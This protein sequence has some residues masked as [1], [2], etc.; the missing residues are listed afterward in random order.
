MKESK[1][2]FQKFLWFTI[3]LCV[4]LL[5]VTTFSFA[6]GG[7]EDDF[8]GPTLDSAWEVWPGWNNS[9]GS[10]SI[11]N[12]A[13]QYMLS[14][15]QHDA[16]YY[17]TPN[18]SGG[19]TYYPGLLLAR[20]FSGDKWTFETK[21]NYNMPWSN[22]RALS[23]QIWIGNDG[24]RPSMGSSGETF[25][26]VIYRNA[27]QAGYG[28]GVDYLYVWCWPSGQQIKLP[29]NTSHFR[30]IRDGY[31]FTLM[32]SSDGI[33]Y[34]TAFSVTAPSSVDGKAQKVVIGGNSWARPA[35]SYEAYDYIKVKVDPQPILTK[36]G[37]YYQHDTTLSGQPGYPTTDTPVTVRAIVWA[38][39]SPN[40][41]E[42]PYT[43]EDWPA[44]EWYNPGIDGAT[45]NFNPTAQNLP[46]ITE[47]PSNWPQVDFEWKVLFHKGSN[48]T[49]TIKDCS[50]PGH[51]GYDKNGNKVVYCDK[52]RNYE[53]GYYHN[54]LWNSW[55]GD[56]ISFP[57]GNWRFMVKA[58]LDKGTPVESPDEEKATRISV[59]D[60]DLSIVYGHNYLKWL[61]AYL[62]VPYEWGGY[63]FGG[64]VGQDVG[65]HVTYEDYGI[66][67]S[68]FV[69]CGA[70]WS[71]YNWS[72]WRTSTRTLANG[73]P[74]DPTYYSSII[75]EK[76]LAPGDI[77]N[78]EGH[79]V[80]TIYKIEN[81]EEGTPKEITVIEA[82]G[83]PDNKVCFN[84]IDWK[85]WKKKGYKP[86]RLT[87]H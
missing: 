28:A 47:W 73:L 40:G 43:Q 75:N 56:N 49:S 42:K 46:A 78:W 67:C 34:N 11:T 13:L 79:H 60:N 74:G 59:L 62:G 76:L 36:V 68:G 6:Q 4:G 52:N 69:S 64:K 58:I 41:V 5:S 38:K 14:P 3:A 27:D 24:V 33:N 82:K 85:S 70:R 7:F 72:P 23:T 9:Y 25:G 2:S 86:R 22:G 66:D 87:P 12:G 10:Y 55:G 15:W 35:G 39:D 44:G 26:I 83:K 29:L 31:N 57:V 61:T 80:Q 77:L 48:P 30:V 65:G 18:Q 17:D 81:Y 45:V 37:I 21:V 54:F 1:K 8:S 71:G 63:W 84:I 32:S 19:Y 51:F 16:A 20:K 53:Y 50:L